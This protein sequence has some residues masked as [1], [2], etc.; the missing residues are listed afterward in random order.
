MAC[1]YEY[2]N[3]GSG[4]LLSPLWIKRIASREPEAGEEVEEL[5]G[6]VNQT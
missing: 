1:K 3:M 5:S 2:Q 4:I 6:S